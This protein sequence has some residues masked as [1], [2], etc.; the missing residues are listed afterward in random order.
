[1]MLF[2]GL[3]FSIGPSWKF[4]CRRPWQNVLEFQVI[5]LRGTRRGASGGMR[6]GAKALEAH[7]HTLFKTF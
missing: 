3:V 5:T 7:Q 6:L 1:M 2:F 4:F